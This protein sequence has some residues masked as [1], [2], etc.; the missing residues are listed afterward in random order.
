MKK[1]YALSILSL[2][3][4]S[5]AF[6]DTIIIQRTVTATSEICF[7]NSDCDQGFYCSKSAG[8]CDGGG[9]CDSKPE[10]CICPEYYSPV[11]GCDGT[12]YDNECFAACQG[13]S[14]AY[15][16]ECISECSTWADVIEKYQAYKN[17][18]GSLRDVIDCYREWRE[19]RMDR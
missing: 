6:A 11:C 5:A 15:F 2:F 4:T 18:Q 3:L 8:D 12:T 14:I 17:N 19:E 16:G 10:Q 13:A 1:I 7:D 9:V